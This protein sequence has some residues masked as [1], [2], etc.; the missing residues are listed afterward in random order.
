MVRTGPVSRR[1]MRTRLVM[2]LKNFD[3]GAEWCRSTP[4]ESGHSVDLVYSASW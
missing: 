1:T 2:I 4:C 3:D